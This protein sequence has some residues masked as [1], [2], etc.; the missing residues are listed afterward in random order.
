MTGLA[1]IIR[2][3]PAFCSSAECKKDE[4]DLGCESKLKN[5][6]FLWN[7]FTKIAVLMLLS[8]V[9]GIYLISTTVMISKD[10]VLYVTL[11]QR[12]E[13]NPI[14]AIRGSPPGY[15]F[16]IFGVQKVISTLTNDHSTQ[17]WVY[18]G[19]IASLLCKTLAIIPLFFIGK[20]FVGSKNSFFA[21]LA[22]TFLPVPN[23]FVSDIVREWA[24][25][26]FLMTGFA[27]LLWSVK[28]RSWWGLGFVGLI[29]GMGCLIRYECLQLIVYA[30]LWVGV[31]IIRPKLW[32]I[33]LWKKAL[34]V[35]LLLVGFAGP[36]LPYMA[37]L[38]KK[39]PW[40]LSCVTTRIPGLLFTM[41]GDSEIQET[42]TPEA[43]QKTVPSVKSKTSFFS[44][45][46]NGLWEIF[47]AT[48]E[49]LIW[50]YLPF[51]VI[52]FIYHFRT[53]PKQTEV[54]FVTIFL[55]L[56]I[57][58]I[59][60]RYL[61]IQ[62]IVSKRWCLGMVCMLIFYV[63][64]G[65]R[66]ITDKLDKKIPLRENASTRKMITWF[67][68]LFLGSIIVCMPKLL[69]P[70]RI[71]KQG[72]R[73]TSDWIRENTSPGDVVVVPDTRIAFYAG[74][75]QYDI[76]N[77]STRFMVKVFETNKPEIA[78]IEGW[79]QRFATWADKSEKTKRIVIFERID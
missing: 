21:L 45:V 7:D 26:L 53:G 22:L 74:R 73:E 14:S 72:F 78:Y 79:Q 51:A 34:A 20:L 58:I 42:D 16:L 3:E 47:Q 66:F 40:S 12:W 71:H 4:P 39:N 54:F 69:V 37:S 57:T 13:I 33:R 61:A 68:V 17:V 52:G 65:L 75:E 2:K 8:L 59:I 44:P 70:L 77:E 35:V 31:S 11:A 46:F 64:A 76:V 23:R 32:P 56:N 24:Y 29:T 28:C 19:Q 30:L 25:I 9:V 15:T 49:N 27:V 60:W 10:G 67:S 1:N 50:V 41:E 36:F 6:F 18:S 48:G 43:P 5:L 62:P 55:L 38:D 63:P